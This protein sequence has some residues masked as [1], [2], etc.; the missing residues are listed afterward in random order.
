VFNIAFV[1]IQFKA[2]NFNKSIFKEQGYG[3]QDGMPE[4]MFIHNIRIAL[5]IL[6]SM[7][8]FSVFVIISSI[9]LLLLT[10]GLMNR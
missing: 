1:V 2:M 7:L 10:L 5:L 6:G 3:T 4:S 8:T 9:F